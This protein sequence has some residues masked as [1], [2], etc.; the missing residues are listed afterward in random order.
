MKP[1][2]R[3]KNIHHALCAGPPRK[4]KTIYTIPASLPATNIQVDI[5]ITEDGYYVWRPHKEGV[6]E[7]YTGPGNERTVIHPSVF[8]PRSPPACAVKPNINAGV[9]LRA[10]SVQ[11]FKFQHAQ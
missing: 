3:K 1:G 5:G 11:S 10:R 8:D 4:F 2:L 7:H 6:R 9:A